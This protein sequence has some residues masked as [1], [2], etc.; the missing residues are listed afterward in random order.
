MAEPNLSTCTEWSITSSAGTSGF[1]FFGSPPSVHGFAHGGQI[2][3]RGHPGEILQQHARGHERN[4]LVLCLRI[5]LASASISASI[6]VTI[7]FLTEQIFE[8]HFERDR[9]ARNSADAGLFD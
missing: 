8:Q 4:F 6:D 3:D 5:P 7:V 2:D 1:I 9:Q